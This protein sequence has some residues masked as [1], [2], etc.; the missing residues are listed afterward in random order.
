MTAVFLA[1]LT[2]SELIASATNPPPDRMTATTNDVLRLGNKNMPLR[3]IPEPLPDQAGAGLVFPGQVPAESARSGVWTNWF[4]LA[5]RLG[6]GSVA[7]GDEPERELL[8]PAESS[9]RTLTLGTDMLSYLFPAD[10]NGNKNRPLPDLK[11]VLE[12]NPETRTYELRRL[13][14]GGPEGG[15]WIGRNAQD[16]ETQNEIGFQ[17]RLKW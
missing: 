11:S 4:G 10:E 9:P 16:E 14:L 7:V 2:A 13:E 8:E 1:I 5:G 15:L 3:D 12:W 17:W 6:E